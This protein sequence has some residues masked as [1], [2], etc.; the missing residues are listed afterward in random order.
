MSEKPEDAPG[1]GGTVGHPTKPPIPE[2]PKG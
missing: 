1:D 2:T